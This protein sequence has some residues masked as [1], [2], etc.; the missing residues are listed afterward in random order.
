[1]F[2]VRRKKV[3]R[4]MRKIRRE[5]APR[6]HQDTLSLPLRAHR[7]PSRLWTST[8]NRRTALQER[9][10]PASGRAVRPN[11]AGAPSTSGAS[12]RTVCAE[13]PEEEEEEKAR[14][15]SQSENNTWTLRGHGGASETTTFPGGFLMTEA[16]RHGNLGTA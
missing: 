4:R 14:S 3:Q 16:E 1:M 10:S 12:S 5:K 7:R 8:P 11:S 13:K 9:N 6:N 15:R 2:I